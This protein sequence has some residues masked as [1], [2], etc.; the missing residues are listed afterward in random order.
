VS[1]VAKQPPLRVYCRQAVARP[2]RWLALAAS[3]VLFAGAACGGSTTLADGGGGS[4]GNAS[5]GGTGGAVGSA[6]SGGRAGTAGG[7]AGRSGGWAC[8]ETAGTLCFCIIGGTDPLASCTPGWTC[9]FAALT[10]PGQGS[11]DCLNAADAACNQMVAAQPGVQRVAS[12][13]PL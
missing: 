3:V 9:C 2:W 6:G 7:S 11:C 5:G 4:A 8:G 12:C 1:L 10:T 13:P